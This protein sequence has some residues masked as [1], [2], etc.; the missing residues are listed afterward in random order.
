MDGLG[1]LGGRDGFEVGG[2]I[3][4]HGHRPCGW[5]PGTTSVPSSPTLNSPLISLSQLESEHL[6]DTPLSSPLSHQIKSSRQQIQ[7]AHTEG[8]HENPP[9]VQKA[10]TPLCMLARAPVSPPLGCN[11]PMEGCGGGWLPFRAFM[12]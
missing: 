4:G 11:G 5:R 12:H 6:I 3:W 7:F 2:V 8:N 10:L 9:S 1:A